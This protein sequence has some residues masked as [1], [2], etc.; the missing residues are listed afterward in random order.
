MSEKM[1]PFLKRKYVV[2]SETPSTLNAAV[3]VQPGPYSC[4]CFLSTVLLLQW[5]KNQ[6]LECDEVCANESMKP[7]KLECYLQSKHPKCVLILMFFFLF[8]FLRK[9]DLLYLTFIKKICTWQLGQGWLPFKKSQW[10]AVGKS[11]RNS[12]PSKHSY[13]AVP[14]NKTHTWKV[15]RCCNQRS[16]EQ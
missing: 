1:H 13:I 10:V 9:R 11:L 3:C 6:C 12:A 7:P 2:H 8:V 4:C 15:T 14:W 16:A 5:M